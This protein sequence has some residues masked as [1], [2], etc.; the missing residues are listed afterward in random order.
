MGP[1]PK[2]GYND[3]L[4]YITPV[5]NADVFPSTPFGWFCPRHVSLLA[6]RN[7]PLFALLNVGRCERL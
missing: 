6:W 5:G 2:L 7:V 3:W 1:V 4:G